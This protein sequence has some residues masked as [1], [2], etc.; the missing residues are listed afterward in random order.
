ML[1][2][3]KVV[4]GFRKG[5]ATQSVGPAAL[6]PRMPP[7]ERFPPCP[8]TLEHLPHRGHQYFEL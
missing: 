8:G 6:A 7:L 5:D 2:R 1:E 4:S 3:E